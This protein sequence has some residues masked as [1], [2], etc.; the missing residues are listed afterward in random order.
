[1]VF[2]GWRKESF[3]RFLMG[4]FFSIVG[5][6]SVA[7]LA[8]IATAG[9]RAADVNV[10]LANLTQDLELLSREVANLR[11]EVELLR[12]ENAQLRIVVE[13]GSK[14]QGVSQ[15][16]LQEFGRQ[17]DSRLAGVRR[18]IVQS[19]SGVQAL[20]QHVDSSIQ[21]LIKQMNIGFSDVNK[22]ALTSPA[23]DSEV[24]AFSDKYPKDKGFVHVVGK[25]ET[26]SSIA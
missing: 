2:G 24:L 20:R 8:C 5:K 11:S 6:M 23:L 9:L 26:V 3:K 10:R 15:A 22:G 17:M 25:G 4:S 13:Q 21:R 18:E 16:K 12:R 7:F 1:M 19:N 14:T